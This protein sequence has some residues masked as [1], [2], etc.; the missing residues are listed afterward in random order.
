MPRSA[1]ALQ[2]LY[3]LAESNGIYLALCPTVSIS[4]GAVA[5]NELRRWVDKLRADPVQTGD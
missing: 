4:L 3:N 1:L 5:T 2:F